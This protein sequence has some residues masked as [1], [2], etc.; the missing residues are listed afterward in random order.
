MKVFISADIEGIAGIAHWDEQDQTKP[1]YVEFRERMTAHVAAACEGAAAAG[2]TEVVVRDAHGSGRNIF[3]DRLPRCTRVIR[4]WSGDPLMMV[5]G[6]DASFDALLMVGYHARAGSNGNPL[7]HTM[8]GSRIALME[9]AGTPI[10]EFH[11]YG[12][13]GTLCGV[14]VPFVTG[15][16]AICAQVAEMNPR[17]TTVAVLDGMGAAAIAMHPAEAEERIRAGVTEALSGDLDACML[18]MPDPLLLRITYKNAEM[19]YRA[20]FYPGCRLADEVRVEFEADDY[21]EILRAVAF[22]SGV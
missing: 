21:Y 16:A 4:G 6:L 12:L 20:S 8:S 18:P 17:V 1:D 14:P 3:A 19:A 10:A 13:A 11:L 2:A 7:A 9:L 22:L 15:D 5:E